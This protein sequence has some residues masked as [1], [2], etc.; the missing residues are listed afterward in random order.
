MGYRDTQVLELGTELGPAI[1]YLALPDAPFEEL[2]IFFH[3][4][5]KADASLIDLVRR[6]L[7]EGRPLPAIAV[8]SFGS[9]WNL[10][11]RSDVRPFSSSAIFWN[12]ILPLIEE[13]L[14]RD[15]RTIGIGYSMGG[16]NLLSLFAD[17]PDAW[18]A[19]AFLNPA[20]T[21]LSPAASQEAVDA[22]VRRTKAYTAK[23]W[24]RS[25]FGYP[26]DTNIRAILEARGRLVTMSDEVWK[27]LSPLSRLEAMEGRQGIRV[28]VLVAYATRDEFGFAEGGARLAELLSDD[29]ALRVRPFRGGHADLPVAAVRDFLAGLGP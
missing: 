29:P 28:P 6:F 16:F 27:E 17:R 8:P 23:Q 9:Q 2:W 3:G 13:G 1:V 4:S 14:G 5:G 11:D 19:L 12:R 26:L 25:F 22:Y 15:T 18:D 10:T 20:L 24:L 7:P 21:G